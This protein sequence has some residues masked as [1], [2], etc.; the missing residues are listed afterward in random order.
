MTAPAA[1]QLEA[2]TTS[3]EDTRAFAAA[4]A[5]LLEPGDVVLLVGDLGAGKTTFTQG[6]AAG[7]GVAEQVTSPTFTLVRPYAC[8]AAG[9]VRTLHH[10]DLYRLD[11]LQ[12]VVDLGLG[13]LVEEQ[14]VAVVEWGDVGE[15]VLGRHAL[16]VTLA[17]PDTAAGD[18]SDSDT[19]RVVTLA[20]P[21]GRDPGA[22]RDHLARWMVG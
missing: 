15:P 19:A 5:M 2:R 21:P 12:E 20:L 22:W 16:T 7:L 10:A 11:H 1:T 17:T 14:A 3:P 18:D 8:G 4:L 13:E 6:L 9:A